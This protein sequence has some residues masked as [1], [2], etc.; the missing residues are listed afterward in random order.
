MTRPDQTVRVPLSECPPGP[1]MFNG[2][3]GFK[4]EYGAIEPVGPTNVPGPDVRWTVGTRPDAYCMDSGECFWGGTTK[5]ADR[6]A[7]MV[8]PVDVIAA[9]EVAG[10][11][12]E[13]MAEAFIQASINNSPEPLKKLGEFLT[14]VLDEHHWATAEGYLLALASLQRPQTPPKEN[15]H[16]WNIERDGDALLICDGE[17][18]KSEGC[19]F[20][21][22]VRDRPQ[23][24]P[25]LPG[26]ETLGHSAAFGAN[27]RTDSGL[28]VWYGS[29]PES[30][31]RSNW[32][33]TLHRK[34][35]DVHSDG[36]CFARSEY[37]ERVRYE[38][39]EMR[40]IIGELSERPDILAYDENLHSGYV[41]PKSP[42]SGLVDRLVE[43]LERIQRLSL[44]DSTIERVAMEA[45]ARKGAA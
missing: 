42:D 32:T 22:Y 16:R 35:G 6:D 7:L 23:T 17:H 41:A 18:E 21:R 2:R 27:V 26:V 24:T 4:T 12:P 11:T 9:A 34:G 10:E 31:G 20:E 15:F 25:M 33:A 19:A 14:T 13:Q 3:L 44:T 8:T 36:F 39:D 30:N 40:W 29:M 43:A 1:F 45:L 38:A 37:P 28:S 5:H